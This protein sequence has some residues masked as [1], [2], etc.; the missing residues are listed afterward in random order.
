[1][2]SKKNNTIIEVKCTVSVMD[3]LEQVDKEWLQQY[4]D[5]EYVEDME[6]TVEECT[7]DA[8]EAMDALEDEDVFDADWAKE[9]WD[10]VDEDDLDEE[11]A[12]DKFDL[13]SEDDEYLDRYGDPEYCSTDGMLI[14]VAKRE[15]PRGWLDKGVVIEALVNAVNN[16]DRFYSL[17]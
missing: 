2:G 16:S 12:K 17:V 14:E 3:V 5:D 9:R 4:L 15:H 8:D 13:I 7:V 1:M 11:W 6:V 10:L